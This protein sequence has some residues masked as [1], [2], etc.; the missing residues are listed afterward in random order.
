MAFDLGNRSRDGPASQLICA[1]FEERPKG[2]RRLLAARGEPAAD[3]DMDVAVVAVV[4]LDHHGSGT[5]PLRDAGCWQPLP[6]AAGLALTEQ[7]QQIAD[8]VVRSSTHTPCAPCTPPTYIAEMKP[9][10]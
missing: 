10:F 5:L 9:P 7:R 3:G 6:G 2:V 8:D 1:P 4:E